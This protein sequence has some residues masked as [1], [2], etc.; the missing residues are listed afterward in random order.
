M[1]LRCG[2]NKNTLDTIIVNNAE[3]IRTAKTERYGNEYPFTNTKM[4][5]EYDELEETVSV[6]ILNTYALC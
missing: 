6:F 3:I 1:H 5:Q 4:K 2:F